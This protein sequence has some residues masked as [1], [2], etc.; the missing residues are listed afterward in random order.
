[1]SM[2][3]VWGETMQERVLDA[4]YEGLIAYSDEFIPDLFG[5]VSGTREEAIIYIE[6]PEGNCWEITARSHG[7]HKP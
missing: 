4:L 2:D 3:E 5:Y 7:R 6:D 1:M